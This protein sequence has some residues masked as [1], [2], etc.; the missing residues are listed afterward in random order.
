MVLSKSKLV[1]AFFFFGALG[2]K[3]V[4]GEPAKEDGARNN[5]IV[6]EVA[7][8]LGSKVVLVIDKRQRVLNPG[9]TAPEG[10][11]VIDVDSEGATLEVDGERNYYTLGSSRVSTV[12]IK[13]EV[14][15]EL[16]YKD[17]HGMYRTGGYI[18][19]LPVNFLVDT[20]ATTVAMNRNEARRLGVD[21]IVEGEPAYVKTAS[22]VSEAYRVKL[23]TI[24]VGK[25][26][27]SNVDAMVVDSDSPEEVLLG[28]SFLGRLNVQHQN[29]VMSLQA[30]F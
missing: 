28:M 5:N 13:P 16:I 18:N 25:I 2:F 19:G 9:E 24:A 11:K 10:V 27:F 26:R 15:E 12:F 4:F 29:E 30:T 20:G 7:G 22:G 17:S 3:S 6:I 1:M 21:Y 23:K 8:I 14:V